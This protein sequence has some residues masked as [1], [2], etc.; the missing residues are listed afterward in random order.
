MTKYNAGNQLK[1]ISNSLIICHDHLNVAL[2]SNLPYGELSSEA[3]Q[4]IAQIKYTAKEQVKQEI[5]SEIDIQKNNY[6]E[7]YK[8]KSL[9]D[10][11]FEDYSEIETLKI[12]NQL[13]KQLN[14]ELLDKN[15]V[16]NELFT[17]EKQS[18]N[19][20]IKTYAEITSNPKSK[21]KRVPKLII[22]K[23]DKKDST[24][25]EKT[26]LQL[27]TQDKTIQTKSVAYKNNDTLIINCMNEENI[28]SLVNT[29]GEKL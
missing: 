3:N 21:S 19:N 16:L 10:T 12:E 17:K 2:A 28:N 15:R 13:L 11:V 29:L 9:D 1:I 8:D 27:L 14:N 4:L 18:R 26:V 5:I 7:N 20:N 23:T 22:K 25:L 24:D 6:N